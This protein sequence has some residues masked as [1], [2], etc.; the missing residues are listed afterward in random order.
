[1]RLTALT[2][3]ELKLELERI[4]DAPEAPRPVY[5]CTTANMPMAADYP[6]CVLLNTTLNV[7]AHS[8]GTSWFRADTGTAI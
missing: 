4:F 2:I 3:E 8:N 6:N 5:A 1:M 7:L